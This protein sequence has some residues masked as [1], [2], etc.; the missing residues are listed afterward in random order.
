MYKI[1]RKIAEI[2]DMSTSQFLRLRYIEE[3]KSTVQ[4][5]KELGCNHVSV[6]QW[7]R[8]CEIKIRTNSESHRGRLNHQYGKSSARKYDI[9][10]H[11]YDNLNANSCW[12]IGFLSADG[13]IE[14]KYRYSFVQKEI[15]PLITIARLL[16]YSGKVRPHNG[17]YRLRISNAVHIAAL[18]RIGITPRKSLT[19][20]MPNIPEQYLWDFIRGYFD[21]D[22]SVYFTFSEANGKKYKQWRISFVG[23]DSFI[24][25]INRIVSSKFCFKPVKVSK[26]KNISM[27]KYSGRMA[28]TI[29]DAIYQGSKPSNRLDRKYKIYRIF[30]KEMQV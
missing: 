9:D 4:I 29:L 25:S 26:W 27:V 16:K 23:S 30:S 24:R 13:C 19:L 20:E 22:G 5:A 18:K 12:V 15:Q 7:L 2:S 14:N 1:E 28:L 3:Q 10:E 6:A 21:G 11:F 17:L 8:K